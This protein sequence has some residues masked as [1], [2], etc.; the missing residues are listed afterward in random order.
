MRGRNDANKTAAEGDNNLS[1][2]PPF[3]S[4]VYINLFI[5]SLNPLNPS[6]QPLYPTPPHTHTSTFSASFNSP[7]LKNCGIVKSQHRPFFSFSPCRRLSCCCLAPLQKTL[8]LSPSLSL[9][10]VTCPCHCLGFASVSSEWCRCAS[11]I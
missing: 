9:S 4:V 8:P 10:S 1:S 6:Q 11:A 5:A 3:F 2:P 7:L